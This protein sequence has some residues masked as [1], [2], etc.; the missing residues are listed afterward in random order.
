MKLKHGGLID[1]SMCIGAHYF[2][3]P[4]C[5]NLLQTV[6]AARVVALTLFLSEVW[7]GMP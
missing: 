3:V 1:G 2:Q 6:W 4:C 7:S 5:S